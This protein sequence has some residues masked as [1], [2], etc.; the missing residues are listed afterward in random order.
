MS[1]FGIVFLYV[2]MSITMVCLGFV[3]GKSLSTLRNI[4]KILRGAVIELRSI[5]EVHS[6][7]TQELEWIRQ[8]QFYRFMKLERDVHPTR[9]FPSTDSGDYYEQ[10]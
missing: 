4:Q 10:S 9:F 1:R 3:L 7:F 8:S 5:Q 2:C 6:S